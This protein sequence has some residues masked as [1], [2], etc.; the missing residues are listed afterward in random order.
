[1]DKVSLSAASRKLGKNENKKLRVDG[2]IPAVVYGGKSNF[3]I[4]INAREFNKKFQ[5]VSEN[6]I[7]DLDIDGKTKVQVLIKDYQKNWLKD[8]IGHL[9]F[10]EI[11]KNKELKTHVPIKILGIG[12]SVGEK[13]GG[14]LEIFVHDIELVCLPK[15]T[16]SKVEVDISELNIGESIKIANLDLGKGIR[17]TSSMDQVIVVIEHANK[18]SDVEDETSDDD[19]DVVVDGEEAVE[20]VAAE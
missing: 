5:I 1:M 9:D 3:N 17:I 7:I 10:L 14:L 6:T 11:S 16:P 13:A 12:S 15:D 18:A 2:M 8:T 4:V 20:E 19:D